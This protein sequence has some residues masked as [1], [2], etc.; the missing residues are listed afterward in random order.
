MHLSQ[1]LAILMGLTVQVAYAGEKILLQA[2][3][4][5]GQKVVFVFDNRGSSQKIVVRTAQIAAAGSEIQVSVD[6][7]QRPVFRHKFSAEECK[8][9]DSI[10]KCEIAIDESTP[11]FGSIL[12][13]FRR[14]NRAR[15]TI[16]DS[17][18]VRMDVT[19]GLSAVAKALRS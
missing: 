9:V 11:S 13:R 2:G 15:I 19:V 14:G 4:P 17:G 1:T 8:Y 16:K 10:S 7:S 6:E 3:E 18:G 12:Y 5:T